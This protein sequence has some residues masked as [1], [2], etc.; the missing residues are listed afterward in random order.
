M[1]DKPKFKACPRC[2]GKGVVKCRYQI[3][4]KDTKKMLRIMKRHGLTQTQLALHLGLGQSTVTGWFNSETNKYGVI[5]PIYFELLK[6][7]GIN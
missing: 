3:Q 4:T 7:K 1:T 2:K 5:K 6:F